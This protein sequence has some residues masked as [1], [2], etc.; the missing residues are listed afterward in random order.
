M[1]AMMSGRIEAGTSERAKNA[2]QARN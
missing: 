2:A 1:Q